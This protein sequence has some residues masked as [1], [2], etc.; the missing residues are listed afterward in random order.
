V[1]GRERSSGDAAVV[2]DNY[3]RED[4]EWRRTFVED[5]IERELVDAAGKA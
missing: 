4:V 2:F 5:E 3:C 1:A